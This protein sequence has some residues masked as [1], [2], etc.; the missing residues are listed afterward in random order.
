MPSNIL[1]GCGSVWLERCVRDAEAGGSNPLTPTIFFAHNRQSP[2]KSKQQL[3]TNLLF[4]QLLFFLFAEYFL[5]SAK[6]SDCLHVTVRSSCK[7]FAFWQGAVACAPARCG[8]S[9]LRVAKSG[10]QKKMKP[11]AKITFF[12]DSGEDRK[13]MSG[14]GECRPKGKNDHEMSQHPCK[15]HHPAA[16]RINVP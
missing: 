7:T 2:A 14:L 13:E 8:T 3:L 16:L 10:R 11:S 12:A 9:P 4:V 1:S 15:T 5:L 6:N